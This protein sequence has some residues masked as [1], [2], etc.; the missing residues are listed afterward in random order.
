MGITHPKR[1]TTSSSES[2]GSQICRADSGCTLKPRSRRRKEA[3][4]SLLQK[5]ASYVGGYI[6]LNQ[7]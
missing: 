4:F 1:G 3:E 7:P 5:S 6:F 2:A